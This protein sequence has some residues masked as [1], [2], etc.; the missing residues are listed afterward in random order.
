M[1]T[2]EDVEALRVAD[3]AAG[4]AADRA[5]HHADAHAWRIRQ[6]ADLRKVFSGGWKIAGLMSD[7]SYAV[8]RA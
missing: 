6:R 3:R 5:R 2:P 1:L 4:R 7:G 8:V